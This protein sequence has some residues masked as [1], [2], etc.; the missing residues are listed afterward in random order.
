VTPVGLKIEFDF[1]ES[2]GRRGV[3][4]QRI[5]VIRPDEVQRSAEK[6]GAVSK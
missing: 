1:K 6:W 5:L 2:G 4:M 3:V